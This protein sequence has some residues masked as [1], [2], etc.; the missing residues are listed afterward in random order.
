MTA[1]IK[2]VF[3]THNGNYGSPRVHKTLVEQGVI[4]NRKRVER[5]MREERLVAKAATP[6]RTV[7]RRIYERLGFLA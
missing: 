1:L 3:Q 2:D 5:I 4:I 7:K 6:P